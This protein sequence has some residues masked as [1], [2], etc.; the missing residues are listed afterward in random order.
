[1]GRIDRART[2]KNGRGYQVKVTGR[3][4]NYKARQSIVHS[5]QSSG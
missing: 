2:R 4:E 3:K 5:R 1:M